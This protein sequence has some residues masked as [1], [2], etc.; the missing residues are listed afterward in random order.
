[1]LR[2]KVILSTVEKLGCSEEEWLERGMFE[3]KIPLSCNVS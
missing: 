2:R 3:T 1:M